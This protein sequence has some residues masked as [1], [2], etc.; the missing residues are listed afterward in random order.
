[1]IL[2][3]CSLESDLHALELVHPRY[4]D[5]GMLFHHPRGRPLNRDWHSLLHASGSAAP[6]SITGM[7]G[8]IPRGSIDLLEID[9]EGGSVHEQIVR[10]SIPAAPGAVRR[11]LPPP[12]PP[13]VRTTRRFSTGQL[14]APSCHELIFGPTDGVGGCPLDDAQGWWGSSWRRK[15]RK[16]KLDWHSG[17]ED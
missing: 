11:R 16:K 3:G 1:M 2:L 15:C 12:R 8:I 4:V 14:E 17:D 10:L 9:V 5:T 13:H 7:E 6:Y